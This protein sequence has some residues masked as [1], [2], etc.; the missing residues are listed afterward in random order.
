MDK[1]VQKEISEI[2]RRAKKELPKSIS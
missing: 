2:I 1:D